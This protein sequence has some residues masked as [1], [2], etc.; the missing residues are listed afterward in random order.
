MTVNFRLLFHMLYLSLFKSKQTGLRKGPRRIRFLVWFF[1]IFIYD[2][3]FAW[4][5]FLL[6]N[7][8]FPGFR[9]QKV[10]SPLFIIGNFRSGTTF[11]HRLL[12]KD[13]K[14]FTC[15]K[16][17]EI[18]MA[19]SISQRKFFR[20]IMIV[21]RRL[22]GFITRRIRKFEQRVLRPIKLH[23]V[24]IYEPEEDEGIFFYIWN[25]L[26]IWFMF[27]LM[28]EMHDYFYFDEKLPLHRKNAIMRY[29]KRCLQRHMYAHGGKKIFLSKNPA[30]TPKIDTILKFFPDAKIVYMARNP[31]GMFP[32][33]MSWF[34]FCWEYL[35]DLDEKFLFIDEIIE[36]S[37]YWYLYPI[38][39]LRNVP[40]EQYQVIKYRAMIDNPEQVVT[41]LYDRL[42]LPLSRTFKQVLASESRQA[43]QFKKSRVSSLVQIGLSRK[44]IIDEFS[45]VFTYFEFDITRE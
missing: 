20:G 12:A 41:G 8:L 33:Q 15:L 11:L 13:E 16:T 37:R 32:S 38:K 28:K 21:D 29:Y 5:G 30:F 25:S 40:R 39:Y 36:F 44:Q 17:W 42:K 43:K 45:E 22:G 31:L 19:P 1:V 9:K 14:S 34:S 26:F 4:F 3:C 18:Y 23:K 24:G 10:E 35:N 27:P 2:T 6:D 7:L